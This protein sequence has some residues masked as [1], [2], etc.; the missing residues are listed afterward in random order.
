MQ[1]RALC[2]LMLLPT[3]A[4]A[5]SQFSPED[6]AVLQDGLVVSADAFILP[7]YRAYS[8][9]SSELAKAIDHQC[10]DGE[11][12]VAVKATFERSFL[13]WQRASIIQVGPVSAAEGT[14]RVQ[15]W[16]DPK[17]FSQRA[18]RQALARKEPA[19][20]A[21]GGLVGRSIAVTNFTALEHLIYGPHTLDDYA[22]GLAAA[23]ARFQAN[24]AS[25]MVAA[26]TPGSEYRM[27]YD[28]AVDGNE[29]YPS[30]DALLRQLLA[31]TVVYVDRLRKFKLLRG[32]G[33]VPGD[34][35]PERTEANDSDLGLQ[36]I[37]VSFRALADF[38]DTPSGLFDA[39]ADIGGSM[40]YYVL[41]DSAGAIADALVLD[42]ARLTE[43]AVQDGAR[44]EELRGYA[45]RLLQHESFLKSG[46]AREIGLTAGF[47]AADGD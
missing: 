24:L 23:I 37:A 39:A 14:M 29:T 5:Q 28:T 44:A 6:A 27:A 47:T 9:A 43:I 42:D 32:L 13:A 30:V 25:D 36:S 7:A 4:V 17:G 3:F 8:D 15:L 38:Y 2:I 26:W 22:C 34:A 40:D 10:T 20:I 46:F 41:T 45:D 12:M 11:R 35:R 18:V 19:M 21:E 16:P 31:G 33:E 1:I